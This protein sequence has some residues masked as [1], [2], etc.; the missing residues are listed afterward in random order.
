MGIGRREFL[1][2]AAAGSVAAAL[3]QIATSEVRP[4]KPK[5]VLFD[6]FVV[7]DP[8][9]VAA[10]AEQILPG[11]GD[12]L[13]GEWR[14]KQFEYCWIR[15]SAGQYADFWQVTDE[16]LS[17]ASHKL[18][19]DTS[20]AQREQLMDAYLDLQP[21]PDVVPAL[22]KLKEQGVRLAFLSNFTA[23]MLDTNLKR[24]GM[25]ELFDDHLTT[26]L[27][28]AY[29]PSRRAYQM[30]VDAFQVEK[31]ELAFAAFGGWDASGAKWFGY[32]TAWVNRANAPL[33]EFG[34]RPDT[35][36]QGIDTLTKFIAGG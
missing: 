22:K 6:G 16:A 18:K 9:S 15:T 11:K 35:A 1:Q 30:G 23:A 27:V 28:Q 36:G 33:E 21:W 31:R 12:S 25:R 10:K 4:T 13:A 19:L 24:N 26:D 3:P 2:L 8:R 17:F 5:A 14:T 20:K 7:F 32:P 34:V 29:K